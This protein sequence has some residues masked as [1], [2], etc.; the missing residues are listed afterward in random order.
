MLGGGGRGYP[1]GRG[2]LVSKLQGVLNLLRAGKGHLIAHLHRFEKIDY[3][4]CQQDDASGWQCR[5]CLVYLSNTLSVVAVVTGLPPTK[6]GNTRPTVACLF[7]MGDL[8]AAFFC[9]RRDFKSLSTAPKNWNQISD[10]RPTLPQCLLVQG[11]FEMNW[12]INT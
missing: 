9:L 1:H 2:G 7:N 4:C 12:F 11:V 8:F 5:T 10:D 6:M 3:Y